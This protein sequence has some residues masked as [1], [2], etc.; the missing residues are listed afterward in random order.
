MAASAGRPATYGEVFAV[1]EFRALFAAQVLSVVGDQFA[2]VALA[3]L[4]FDRTGSAGLAALT[5]ALTFLPDL[6]GGPLLSGLADRM[7][8]RR[9]MVICDLGRAVLLALMAVPGAPLWVL[10]VLLVAVQL[11]NS[12]FSAA[13]AAM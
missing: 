13:R 2:R 9:L 6:I 5:Y 3:V 1:A 8:R 4:V 11:L 12:P 10:C 7:P